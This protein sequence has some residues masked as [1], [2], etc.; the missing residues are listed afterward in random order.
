[1]AICD[2]HVHRYAS[3][4]TSTYRDTP[5]LRFLLGAVDINTKLR[6]FEE[7]GS[8]KLDIN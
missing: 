2:A 7:I 1:M 4:P 8:L 5:H 6:K 3:T